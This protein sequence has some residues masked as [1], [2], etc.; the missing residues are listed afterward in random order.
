MTKREKMERAKAVRSKLLK[1][2]GMKVGH[3]SSASLCHSRCTMSC[4]GLGCY[5][6]TQW[7]I[8]MAVTWLV[9]V[10]LVMTLFCVAQL[11]EKGQVI[12][13]SSVMEDL[14]KTVKICE[15][16]GLT[17][18]VCRDGYLNEPKKVG[19]TIGGDA[20]LNLIGSLL[21]CSW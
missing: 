6:E 14:E 18:C 10:L 21:V 9:G 20:L 1:E 4:E 16:E 5:M 11:N 12:A 19:G 17:C 3:L 15:E 13:E 7:P 2:Y 8:M